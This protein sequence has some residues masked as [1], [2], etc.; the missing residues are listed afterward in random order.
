MMQQVVSILAQFGPAGL[1]G[2]LWVY[3]RRQA[4]V[5]ERQI[6]AAHRRI[7]EREHDVAALLSVVKDNTQAM[8]TLQ[9]T[10]RCL[11]DLL[12]RLGGAGRGVRGSEVA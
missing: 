10:Q 3:E 4:G 1:I 12:T 9:Q 11:I 6:E 2:V 8:N 7:V 5:R